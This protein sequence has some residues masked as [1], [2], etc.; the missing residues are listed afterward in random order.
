[1]KVNVKLYNVVTEEQPLEVQNIDGRVV[2]IYKMDDLPKVKKD[3]I[4]QGR[5]EVW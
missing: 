5:F 4:P 1:M 2:E 3:F